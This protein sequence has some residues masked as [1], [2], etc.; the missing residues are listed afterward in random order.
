MPDDAFSALSAQLGAPAPESLREL[1]E[2]EL[3][4]LGAAVADA[5]HRQAA[6]LAE[7]GDRA[8]SHIPRL[9]RGPIKRIVG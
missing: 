2:D 4:D 9:L 8:L 3:R 5:R 6:A 1:T 7:A